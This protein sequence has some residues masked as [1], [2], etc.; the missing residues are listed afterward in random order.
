MFNLLMFNHADW[1]SDKVVEVPLGRLFEYTEDRI[2]INLGDDRDQALFDRVSNWPCLFCEEGR[3]EELAYVGEI[4]GAR[5]NQSSVLFDIS[6]DPDVPPQR[7]SALFA[8]RAEL[9]MSDERE[10]SRNHWAV[11][12]I[13]L[14]RFLWRNRRSLDLG[15][16][17]KLDP[18]FRKLASQISNG[19]A[20]GFI[21]EAIG[22]YENELHRAAVVLSR[23]GA[24]SILYQLVLDKHLVGFNTSAAKH[25][26]KWKSAKTFDDL[27]KMKE[28]TFLKIL[29]DL[30]VIG[31][32][33][34]K[35]LEDCLE[36][37]NACGHPN[38]YKLGEKKVASHLE[39]LLHNV[40]LQFSS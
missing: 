12:D 16:A 2:K 22:A 9:H 19:D 28:S 13:D 33:T 5:L 26:K 40:Y 32:N 8:K 17:K 23:V 18:E 1:S 21:D 14:Y 11:K 24:V 6:L 37:R 29:A 35:A 34:R 31:K 30:S 39:T 20:K 38:K 25:V 10:F 4:K 15:L 27:G 36:S 7:N 3:N